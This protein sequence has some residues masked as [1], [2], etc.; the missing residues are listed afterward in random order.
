MTNNLKN[1]WQ[2]SSVWRVGF[3]NNH[4]G[5]IRR[6]EGG[7]GAQ[8]EVSVSFVDETVALNCKLILQHSFILYSLSPNT[9]AT[10]ENQQIFLAEA[11]VVKDDE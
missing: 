7:G 5:E 1:Q 3:F 2:L 8:N 10:Q 9:R 11:A 4:A 6:N